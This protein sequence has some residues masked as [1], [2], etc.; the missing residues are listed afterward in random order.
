[1]DEWTDGWTDAG[2][3]LQEQKQ[4]VGESVGLSLMQL[5]RG[6]KLELKSRLQSMLSPTRHG[7]SQKPEKHSG[8]PSK[9]LFKI[10]S[11]PVLGRPVLPQSPKSELESCY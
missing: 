9:N 7:F 4:R 1:L 5:I 10:S 8:R 2:V 6:H 3:F 11:R